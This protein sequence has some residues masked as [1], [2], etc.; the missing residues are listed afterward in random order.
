MVSVIIPAY[1]AEHTIGNCLQSLMEQDWP[2]EFEV[3]VVDDG[4]ADSTSQIVDGFTGVRLVRQSNAGPAAAR[5]RGAAEAKGD[6]ILFTDADCVPEI[7]WMSE[8]VRPFKEHPEAV[9]VK[10]R[11]KTRQ[12]K[13][14][15][16]FV[17]LEYEDKYRYMLNDQYIDFIDT[18]S[19][20]FRKDVFLGMN[21]YDTEFPVACAEDVELSFR[22]ANKGYKMIFNH[23]A[24]VYHTHPERI[25]AYLRKKYK[26]AFWRIVAVKKNPNKIMKDSHTPK[27]MKVQLLFP[28]A[29]FISLL[30]DVLNRSYSFTLLLLFLF[31]CTT[32]P[33]A[34]RA[35]KTDTAAGL[36]SP[37]FL[38]L[39][40]IAQFFGV[41]GGMLYLFTKRRGSCN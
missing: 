13:I 4:S 12:K 29:L 35:I 34:L 8:M 27:T 39:R 18:Y 16:R 7:N 23:D 3:I 38:L 11:Y 10:G 26:F 21:G 32:L 28:P 40:S 22:M 25:A 9:G 30:W 37:A 24:V 5:N 33:F 17:Q 20:G 41:S 36:L 1:N 31:L 15:A 14:T 2:G 19:A 6:I